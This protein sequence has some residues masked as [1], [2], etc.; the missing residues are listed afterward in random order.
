M[1]NKWITESGQP[2][3]KMSRTKITLLAGA[4]LLGMLFIIALAGAV[5]QSSAP[6]P[7][8]GG[9]RGL[10]VPTD[11][12][13]VA[14]TSPIVAGA[15]AGQQGWLSPTIP[16]VPPYHEQQAVTG[17]ITDGTYEVG[18]EI[19]PGKYKSAGSA[20]GDLCYWARL[21]NEDEITG[22]LTNHLSD[23]KTTVVIKPSDQYFLTRGCAGWELVPS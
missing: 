15:Q 1:N 5:G 23:G 19:A 9:V 20:P 11:V 3:H 7:L 18:A 2:E 12:A 14:P 22:I 4:G 13:S 16:P 8:S 10:P 17:G 21:K 6:P